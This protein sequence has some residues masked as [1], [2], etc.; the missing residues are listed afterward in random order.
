VRTI[1]ARHRDQAVSSHQRQALLSPRA[2]HLTVNRRVIGF[3][4]LPF[5]FKSSNHARYYEIAMPCDKKPKEY[6]PEHEHEQPE[7]TGLHG[8]IIEDVWIDKY[9]EWEPHLQAFKHDNG[10]LS[11]RYCYYV[12]HGGKKNFAPVP[13]F[14]YDWTIDD[15]RQE[16]KD[17]NALVIE[18]LLKRFIGT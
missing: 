12:K 16:I 5:G 10:D 7:L 4:Y 14:V 3:S 11:L 15:F 17:S 1:L 18:A 2:I 6:T 8:W 13:S 9:P